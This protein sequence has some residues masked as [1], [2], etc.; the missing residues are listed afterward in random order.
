VFIWNYNPQQFYFG[1]PDMKWT[2]HGYY[3]DGKQ[4]WTI[5]GDEHGN[6]KMVRGM[7]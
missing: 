3:F 5:L 1:V 7:K 2:V 6:T 4:E